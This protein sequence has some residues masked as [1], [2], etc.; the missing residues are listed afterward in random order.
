[1]RDFVN[2]SDRDV[3]TMSAQKVA[4][5]IK[6]TTT[7][8]IERYESRRD[9]KDK[10][11]YELDEAMELFGAPQFTVINGNLL[12]NG[13]I[14]NMLNLMTQSTGTKWDNAGAYFGVGDSSVAEVATQTTLQAATNKLFKVMDSTYPQVS[15][16]TATFQSTFQSA[17]ANFGW[18]EFGI[19]NGSGGTTLLNRKVSPQGTKLAGQIWT[20]IQTVT[21]S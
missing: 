4:E 6:R 1:M 18:N 12:L 19:A 13:G 7:W 2:A 3:L 11:T 8:Y 14:T 9:W 21:F 5:G 10:A 17:E 15:A 20:G 16:Q